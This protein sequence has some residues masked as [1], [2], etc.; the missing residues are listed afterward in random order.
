MA[1]KIAVTTAEGRRFV[2][3]TAIDVLTLMREAGIL[4]MGKTNREYM[5]F[6]AR[7]VQQNEGK[8]IRTNSAANFLRDLATCKIVTRTTH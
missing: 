3:V 7:Q 8:R 2:G 4:T 1:R 5:R 6:V